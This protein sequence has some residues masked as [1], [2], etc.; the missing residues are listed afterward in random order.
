[1]VRRLDEV[2]DDDDPS[3]APDVIADR[4]S[5]RRAFSAAWALSDRSPQNDLCRRNSSAVQ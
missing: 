4:R 5:K 3:I 1:M 2:I